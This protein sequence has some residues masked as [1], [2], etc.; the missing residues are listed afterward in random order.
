MTILATFLPT[1][2]KIY[3][4]LFLLDKRAKIVTVTNKRFAQ[5]Q[6]TILIF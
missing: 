2:H 1:L 3:Y 6:I 5:T 4:I